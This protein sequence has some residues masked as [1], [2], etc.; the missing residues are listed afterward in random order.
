MQEKV[1]VMVSQW[2]GRANREAL[3]YK[4]HFAML[5][6]EIS[7]FCI[8]KYTYTLSSFTHAHSDGTAHILGI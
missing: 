6:K 1:W 5:V 8:M 2:P 3:F 7:C 4:K